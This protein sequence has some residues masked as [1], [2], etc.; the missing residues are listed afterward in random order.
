M[1]LKMAK[2]KLATS[3]GWPNCGVA[4]LKLF[5][6][7]GMSRF[8][9]EV[10]EA[11]TSPAPAQQTDDR[12]PPRLPRWGR[13]WRGVDDVGLEVDADLLEEVVVERD[14][15]DFDR[16]LQILVLAQL[17]KQVHDLLVDVLRSG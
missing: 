5:W 7:K 10:R 14:E 8:A 16:D 12:R 15:A 4:R 17:F 13:A 3:A 1:S 9:R 6:R 11:G 2:P